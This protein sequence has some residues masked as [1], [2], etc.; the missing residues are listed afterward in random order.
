MQKNLLM[1]KGDTFAFG[2]KFKGLEEGLD[3]AYFTVSQNLDSPFVF[4]KT[5]NNGIE[6]IETTEEYYRYRVIA[7]PAD[8]ED[9]ETGVYNYS[10]KIN[11]N[12]AK[13][14]LL[15]GTFTII[16]VVPEA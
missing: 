13:Y 9:V 14:T 15:E 12:S 7:D 10:L 5:L 1:V 6:L 2:M 11:I 4:Q 16:Q 3:S 8:T